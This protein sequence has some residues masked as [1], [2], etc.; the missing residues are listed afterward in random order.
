MFGVCGPAIP[1]ISACRRSRISR[2]GMRA[3]IVACD[4]PPPFTK[5]HG[6][7]CCVAIAIAALAA[8]RAVRN[9]S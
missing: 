4:L 2:L 5:Q 6:L 3:M 9:E 7:G 1:P 8:V